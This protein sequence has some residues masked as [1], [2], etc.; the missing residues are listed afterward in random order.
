MLFLRNSQ[1]P[2]KSFQIAISIE[3]RTRSFFFFTL[4][5][6]LRLLL[7]TLPHTLCLASLFA[8]HTDCCFTHLRDTLTLASHIC[9]TLSSTFASHTD[10]CLSHWLLLHVLLHTLTLAWHICVS[11]AS[12][13]SHTDSRFDYC[14]THCLLRHSLLHTL[15]LCVAHWLLLHSLTLCFTHWLF[16]S[17]TDACYTLC[18]DSCLTQGLF[19]SRL[20]RH[21]LPC[22]SHM[23][24]TLACVKQELHVC[25]AP[26]MCVLYVLHVC[27]WC[28]LHTS[29]THIC[30]A[31][32]ASYTHM[33]MYSTYVC[34]LLVCTARHTHTCNTYV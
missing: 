20:W 17:L 25:V 26:H 8:S 29:K 2:T 7:H 32:Q 6:L 4:C 24:V 23:R 12:F 11:F 5:L 14:F 3:V 13:A 34:N 21:T 9:V 19:A 30:G 10:L 18:S 15:T 16:A 22:A 31:T 28:A 1:T 27:V 33:C